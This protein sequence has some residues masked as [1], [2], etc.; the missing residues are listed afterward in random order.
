MSPHADRASSP[1]G[2][3]GGVWT[4]RGWLAV[5]LLAVAIA[6]V[7]THGAGDT[8][9]AGGFSAHNAYKT[10]T[11]SSGS[12]TAPTSLAAHPTGSATK[13]EWTPGATS[14]KTKQVVAVAHM[15]AATTCSSSSIFTTLTASVAATSTTYTTAS[16]TLTTHGTTKPGDW[17]CYQVASAY[18]TSWTKPA[19]VHAQAGFVAT[20]V[21]VSTTLP[22]SSS[23]MPID[24]A[25][26]T[27]SFNQAIGT[28]K[29]Q[30]KPTA[31]YGVCANE[32][33]HELLLGVTDSLTCGGTS[34]VTLGILKAT[35]ST[36]FFTTDTFYTTAKFTVTNNPGT[37]VYTISVTFKTLTTPT[38]PTAFSGTPTWTFMPGTPT[39]NVLKSSSGTLPVCR[40]NLRSA[41]LCQPSVTSKSM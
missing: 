32:T 19:F 21:A 28:T 33:N 4:K 6:L 17:Y 18:G 10:S 29:T 24:T 41:S 34:L 36:T 11:I 27:I 7:G 22:T 20:S 38:P 16:L 15:G 37:G 35:T 1:A 23:P 31:A 25:T 39:T 13:L 9:A 12:L 8:F 26:I 40:T 30:L 5:L 14:T 3:P 2:R